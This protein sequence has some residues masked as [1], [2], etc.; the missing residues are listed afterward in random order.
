MLSHIELTKKGTGGA[1]QAAE[2]L[3]A[4]EYYLG[5]DG[6]Q[7]SR[8]VWLGEGSRALGL[9]PGSEATAKTLSALLDGYAPD[10]ETKLAQN[11]GKQ[12]RTLGHDLTFSADKS[13]SVL[14]AAVSPQER[15]RL[16]DLHHR[17][18]EAA[19][20]F[21]Q[22]SIKARRGHAGAQSVAVDGLVVARVDH[23]SSREQQAQLHSHYCVANLALGADGKFST[24]DAE[25]FE[26]HKHAAGALYR[27]EMAKGL[28]ELG[29]GIDSTREKDSHG[30]ETGQVWHRVAG[31]GAET[32]E[33]FSTRSR[34]IKD[35]MDEHGVSAQEACL[36]T[37]QGKE[38]GEPDASRIMEQTGRELDE[39]R[40]QGLVKW[41]NT[42]QLKGAQGTQV[43]SRS[44]AQILAKLHAHDSSWGRAH[45]VDA[46]AKERGAELGAKGVLAEVEA[47]MGRNELLELSNDHQGRPRWA[48][49]AQDALEQGI[50]AKA[51]ARAGDE[52]VRVPGDLVDDAIKKHEEE[53]GFTLTAEQAKA[54]R[55]VAQDTGGVACITGWAGTGKTATAGAYVKAF[56]ANGQRVIGACAAW[57]AAD[58]LAAETGLETHSTA[59]LLWQLDSGKLKLTNRDVVMLDEAGMVGAGTVAKLQHH[60]DKAGGKLVMVGDAL[61]LQPVEAGAPFRLA[62]EAVGHSALTE[63]RRQKEGRDRELASAFYGAAGGEEIV[64]KMMDRGQLKGY[65]ST[66][67]ARAGLVKAYLADP[68]PARDKLVIAPTNGGARAITSAIRGGLKERGD[69]QDSQ[70]VKVAGALQGETR[71]LELAVGDRVRFGK[72]NKAMGVSNGSIGVVEQI[73]DGKNGHKLAVRL[74]SDIQGRDGRLV[75]VDTNKYQDLDH[76]Y[77][78]TV[79]KAQGQGKETVYWHAEGGS[80]DRHLG[81]VAFTRTKKEIHAFS[82]FHGIDKLEKSLDDWRQKQNAREM[83]KAEPEQAQALVT[84]EQTQA[85]GA[86]LKQRRA[87]LIQTPQAMDHE[88][89]KAERMRAE[90]GQRGR[91][92]E[93]RAKLDAARQ[94]QKP[95][96]NAPENWRQKMGLKPEQ[97]QARPKGPEQAPPKPQQKDDVTQKAEPVGVDLD[98]KERQQQERDAM[99]KQL[100]EARAAWRAKL[101]PERS[102]LHAAKAELA[103]RQ[104]KLAKAVFATGS[105]ERQADYAAK[106]VHAWDREHTWRKAPKDLR[107][108]VVETASAHTKATE[109]QTKKESAVTR[110]GERVKDAFEALGA[111]A[112]KEK[113]TRDALEKV[114]ATCERMKFKHGMENGTVTFADLERETQRVEKAK[115]ALRIELGLTKEQMETPS[116]GPPRDFKI[117]SPDDR[118]LKG[119]RPSLGQRRDRERDNGWGMG[120]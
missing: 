57:D 98:K 102:A 104:E 94:G 92:W 38:G 103:T 53:Q 89:A 90:Q 107:E 84:T 118:T 3:F 17:A 51:T 77:A 45:L 49:K 46:I 16:L 39:M 76:G 44:D 12:N 56:E 73:E 29:Y 37:R 111:K 19:L 23:F 74:E 68:T 60:I 112:R 105:A 32:L 4:S 13:I 82:S 10:G 21:L 50:A 109:Y 6:E 119:P 36:R 87:L 30:R 78:G 66:K 88:A 86:L 48:S 42:D 27:A 114:K 5:T 18:G 54:V 99:A 69:L 41:A 96:L 15:E 64:A 75:S 110:Q 52:A 35:Y 33:H 47:F 70:P 115:E 101:E 100:K 65:D 72:R 120:M 61:Q 25:A 55:W 62:Q 80:A 14:F 26:S 7:L 24:F 63:I 97:E 71:E 116:A 93:A 34:Q 11:A 85:L 113:P 9:E 59:S 43:E 20:D 91:E 2:Y 58:K 108:A 106:Q 1:K 81:L 31:I 67:D 79:H 83:M 40:G 95:D 8:V 28:Q 22:G 117:P